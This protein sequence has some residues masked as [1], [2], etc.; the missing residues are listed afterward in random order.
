M[1][2]DLNQ[3]PTVSVVIP[4]F[5][6]ADYIQV[7]I[8]SVLNQTYQDF[9]IVI[10]DDGSSDDSAAIIREFCNERIRFI[11][12]ETNL[13]LIAT[14]NK[15][16][17]LCRG[18]Y[19]ARLDADDVALPERLARQVQHL[20][21]NPGLSMIG[22][23]YLTLSALPP[24]LVS[25]AS[26][27]GAIQANLLFNS[28]FAHPSVMLRTSAL[29]KRNPVYNSEFPHAEDYELWT[30][31]MRNHS[32]D[33][34]SEPLIYYRIHDNQISNVKSKEQRDTAQRVREQLLQWLELPFSADDYS[35]HRQLAENTIQWDLPKFIRALSHIQTIMIYGRTNVAIESKA[36]NAYL[37]SYI[38]D[39]AKFMRLAG[40]KALRESNLFKEVP[41]MLRWKTLYKCCTWK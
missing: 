6:A 12:N 25:L 15:A 10:I 22:S 7:C 39:K 1:A 16:F 5:N 40:Y 33:N 2:T 27:K 17:D 37:L 18:K 31:L 8:E 20:D 24:R 11:Q 4:V 36:F 23:S 34:L 19:I 13:G 35:F 9:E 32:V 30:W 28:C 41:L 3:I 14:L 29:T 26:G 38:T 21:L